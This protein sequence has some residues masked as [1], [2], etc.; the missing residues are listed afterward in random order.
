MRAPGVACLALALACRAGAAGAAGEL[1][2]LAFVGPTGGLG[3]AAERSDERVDFTAGRF[4][5]SVCEEYG[6]PAAAYTAKREGEAVRFES[7]LV[8]KKDGEIRWRG[9]VRPGAIEATY[10]W[11]KEGIFRTTRKEY[12]FKGAPAAR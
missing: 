5:S 7:V 3:E 1:D 8:S 4:R 11:T 12:W 10:V 9:V 2:G 6:F